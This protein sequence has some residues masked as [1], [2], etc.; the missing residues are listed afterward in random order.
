[1]PVFKF[2]SEMS[3]KQKHPKRKQSHY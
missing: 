2:N 1:M 3:S